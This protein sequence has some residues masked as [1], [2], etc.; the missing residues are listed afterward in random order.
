MAAID[1]VMPVRD[2]ADTL[3]AAIASILWQ[4]EADLRLL[5]V[6]DD[7]GPA[8]REVMARYAAQDAR[9]RIMPT[10]GS[11]IVDALNT[12]L[13]AADAPYVA[14]M[15]GDDIA[16][17]G[18]LAAQRALMDAR[19]D[20]VLCGSPV[21]RFGG[22]NGLA[23]VPDT[24]AD[25]ARA[26]DVF[27]CFYHPSVMIR[28]AALA[29]HGLRYDRRYE[30][31]ED[32][33]LFCDL[34]EIGAVV[35]LAEPQ[36]LYRVHPGQLSHARKAAQDRAALR[37]VAMRAGVSPERGDLPALVAMLSGARRL[38]RRHARRSFNALRNA[39]AAVLR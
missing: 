39:A 5:I 16:L 3:P 1:V 37:V 14:R 28:R 24:A 4:T 9:V 2:G 21:I 19:P 11:G 8:T 23:R 25:C 32:Y 18:R 22:E 26:L 12:G 27:N 38:G 15:D 35:N 7:S 36:L 10:R 29:E 17:P 31:A 6:D 13:D 33:K 34:A 20:V 30:L